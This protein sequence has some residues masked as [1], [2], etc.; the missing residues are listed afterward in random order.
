[1]LTVCRR[2]NVA[3]LLQNPSEKVPQ[4]CQLFCHEAVIRTI[5]KAILM[6]EYEAK[7]VVFDEMTFV[8][9]YLYIVTV[10]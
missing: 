2:I 10:A 1:M 9:L 5:V 8:F 7:N 3:G 4:E 6:I